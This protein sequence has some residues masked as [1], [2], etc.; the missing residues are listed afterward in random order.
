MET[1]TMLLIGVI[2]GGIILLLIGL[3]IYYMYRYVNLTSPTVTVINGTTITG[4]ATVPAT[5]TGTT[6]WVGKKVKA[7]LSSVS[8]TP[9][10]G[11]IATATLSGT[12]VT[13]T[14]TLDTASA[15]IAAASASKYA[16]ASTDTIGIQGSI[17]S[18]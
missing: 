13:F 8:A 6:K 14:V 17:P 10:T 12:T 2:G 15:T 3:F 16:A 11:T 9:L 5:V 7:S 4:T 18:T 1:K